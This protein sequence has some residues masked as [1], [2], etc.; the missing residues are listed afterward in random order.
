MAGEKFL[1]WGKNIQNVLL[2]GE[3]WKSTD[4]RREEK[5]ESVGSGDENRRENQ[6]DER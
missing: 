4:E 1:L 3:R 2:V 5:L 6:A